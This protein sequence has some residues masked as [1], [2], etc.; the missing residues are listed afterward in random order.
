MFS[1]GDSHLRTI[2]LN[3]EPWFLAKDVCEILELSDTSKALIKLDDDEKLTRKVFGSGQSRA[4]WLV[5]ESGLYNLIFRSN[6]PE[7][8]AFRKWVTAE[9]LPA[10]RRKGS[11]ELEIPALDEVGALIQEAS[12]MSGSRARLAIRLGISAASISRIASGDTAPF[13]TVFVHKVIEGCKRIV[14]GGNTVDME[15]VEM[16]IRI[17]D[18][19]IRKGLFAKMKKG[20]L[21]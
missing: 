21:L 13:D 3:N 14:A 12:M 20:G 10:I 11:Y 19:K 7:A 9:V 16:L 2:Q 17:E 1:H 8:K 18:S 15:A 4:M 5:N 6:K